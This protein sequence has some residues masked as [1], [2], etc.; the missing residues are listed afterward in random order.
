MKVVNIIVEKS[1][2]PQ[3]LAKLIPLPTDKEEFFFFFFF[4]LV[5]GSNNILCYSKGRMGEG[6][7]SSDEMCIWE[8]RMQ[9]YLGNLAEKT[10]TLPPLS[11]P[12]TT[13]LTSLLP[14]IP[15]LTCCDLIL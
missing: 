6:K 7:V 8:T 3:L 11:F 10:Y 5:A 14:T 9:E 1:V 15:D 12:S 4:D 2:L 13:Y